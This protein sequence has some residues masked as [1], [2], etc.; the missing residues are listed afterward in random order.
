M[1]TNPLEKG[2]T[3]SHSSQEQLRKGGPAKEMDLGRAPSVS[4]QPHALILL[5]LLF[6][7]VVKEWKSSIKEDKHFE[8]IW[9]KL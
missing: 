2:A 9:H 6:S 1:E 7:L 5:W 4:T 8:D 3:M